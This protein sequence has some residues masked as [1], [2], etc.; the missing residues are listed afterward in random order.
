VGLGVLAV[1]L[2]VGTH[3]PDGSAKKKS[4]SGTH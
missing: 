3:Y 1:F 2:I 4:T